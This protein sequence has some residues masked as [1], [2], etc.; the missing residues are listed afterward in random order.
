MALPNSPNSG[1]VTTADTTPTTSAEDSALQQQDNEAAQQEAQQEAQQN[2]QAQQEQT[3]EQQDEQQQEGMSGLEEGGQM[4]D[5]G[6]QSAGQLFNQ[7]AG[8]AAAQNAAKFTDP[9][10]R[11]LGAMGKGGGIG[12]LGGGIGGAPGGG[13]L[14]P[15]EDLPVTEPQPEQNLLANAEREAAMPETMGRAGAA[16]M[17]YPPGGMPGAGQGGQGQSK[18]K[19]G[20]SFLKKHTNLDEVFRD[21]VTV[22]KSVVGQDSGQDA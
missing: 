21:P 17:G 6:L 8:L 9:A 10:L 16:G 2:Q 12:K 1:I 22:S 20:A 4:L 18:E 3:E 13:S 14:D 15:K 11:N 19:K 7:N 5:T